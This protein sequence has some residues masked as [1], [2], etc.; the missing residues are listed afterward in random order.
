MLIAVRDLKPNVMLAPQGTLSI[1]L[2]CTQA[3]TAYA[4]LV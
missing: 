2:V 1:A 4:V 3:K